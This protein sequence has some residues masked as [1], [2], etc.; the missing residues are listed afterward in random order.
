MHVKQGWDAQ[1]C[2][3]L[4]MTI[5]QHFTDM[6]GINESGAASMRVAQ[7]SH[8]RPLSLLY[9]KTLG[10]D[11]ASLYWTTLPA[12]E[13]WA[14]TQ[15]PI[16]Q[17]EQLRRRRRLHHHVVDLDEDLRQRRAQVAHQEPRCLDQLFRL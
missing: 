9:E 5:I 4:N 7:Q 10:N 13:A 17:G 8:S 2:H 1:T 12:L 15:G 3:P 6:T 11:A 16:T 14:R